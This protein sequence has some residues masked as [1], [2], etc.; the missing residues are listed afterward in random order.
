[1]APKNQS[2]NEERVSYL[3]YVL[4]ESKRSV[5]KLFYSITLF[6]FGNKVPVVHKE[7]ASVDIEE[8]IK[9]YSTVD[10]FNPDSIIIE[11]FTG[12][13]YNIKKPIATFTLHYKR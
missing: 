2:T 5:K 13:S 9:K 1:M 6:R 4:N 8:Q 12:R 11:L 7:S 10:R 3:V